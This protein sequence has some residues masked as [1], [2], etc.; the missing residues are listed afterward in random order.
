LSSESHRIDLTAHTSIAGGSESLYADM[1]AALIARAPRRA[2]PT[3]TGYTK[4][5]ALGKGAF[6][7]VFLVRTPKGEEAVMKEITLKGLSAKERDA[8]LNEVRVLK[9]LSHPHVVAYKDSHSLGETLNICMEYAAGGDLAGR[10]AAK[11][12]VGTRFEEAAVLRIAYQL[13]SALAYCHHDVKMLHRDLKPQNV[14]LSARGDVKLGDFGLSKALAASAALAVT[15][16]GTPLYM[17][18][19]LCEGKPYDRGADVWALGCVL[20][21]MMALTPPWQAQLRGRHNVG[22]GE[23]LQLISRARLDL[24]PLRRHYSAGLCDLVEALL[25]RPAAA[26]PS[27]RAVL[28]SPLMRAAAAAGG[29]AEPA[30]RPPSSAGSAGSSGA[31]ARGDT[32]GT[33]PSSEAS[34]HA[35]EKP[36]TASGVAQRERRPMTPVA[37][38]PASTPGAARVHARPA[39]QP[40]AAQQHPPAGGSKP[41]IF[42]AKGGHSEPPQPDRPAT[43]GGLRARGGWGAAD[44]GDRHR[45]ESPQVVVS[46]VPARPAVSAVR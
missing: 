3:P 35:A 40:G 14:F 28:E 15:Q 9:K 18:P 41:S 21:E 25:A 27:M 46:R 29:H 43:G 38:S 6:G 19:E 7:T 16:C 44:F 32:Q 33:G 36:A 4:L 13:S 5:K 37:E 22:M 34:R 12:S 24:S 10:I 23:L 39:G 1:P 31:A 11:Q 42:A 26:R 8:T 17:S 20:Y 2:P 45:L 30:A